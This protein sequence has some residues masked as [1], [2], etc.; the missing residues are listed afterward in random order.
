MTAGEYKAKAIVRNFVGIVLRLLSR[1]R[2]F[3]GVVFN[4]FAEALLPANPIQSLVT[5][6]LND[7]GGRRIRNAFASPLVDG[8]RKR[9]L[10]RLFRQVEIAKRADQGCYNPP[11]VRNVDSVYR[12]VSVS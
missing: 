2:Q 5:G 4:F 10:C 1:C 9:F 12:R 6:S 7:P 8:R 11:P 3:S